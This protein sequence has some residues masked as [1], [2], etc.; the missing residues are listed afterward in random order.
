MCVFASTLIKYDL[1]MVIYL[2]SISSVVFIIVL[3]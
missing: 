3:V 2:F 1:R